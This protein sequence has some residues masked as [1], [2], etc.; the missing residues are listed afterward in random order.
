MLG[1][2]LCFLNG[3]P[4]LYIYIYIYIYVYIHIHTTHTFTIHM[5][6]D[7]HLPFF[8]FEWLALQKENLSLN[9]R[10][11]PLRMCIGSQLSHSSPLPP[12]LIIWKS[13]TVEHCCRI[14]IKYDNSE[15]S[16]RVW[17]NGSFFYDIPGR[18]AV[19]KKIM[20]TSLTG[21]NNQKLIARLDT[22]SPEKQFKA[23]TNSACKPPIVCLQSVTTKETIASKNTN[24]AVVTYLIRDVLFWVQTLR[25]YRNSNC[26]PDSGDGIWCQIPLDSTGRNCLHRYPDCIVPYLPLWRGTMAWG[27]TFFE[28]PD[29]CLLELDRPR[30]QVSPQTF[31][32]V[33]KFTH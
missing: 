4:W 1:W 8:S 15:A 33:F 31:H 20:Y 24:L 17:L 27:S 2:N 12:R 22:F 11:H 7:S 9:P 25:F 29:S 16:H 18:C 10:R 23:A 28:N 21:K 13:C 26:I 32:T 6:W 14:H 30:M 5:P 3:H 19:Y